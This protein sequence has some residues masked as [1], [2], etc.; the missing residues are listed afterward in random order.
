MNINEENKEQTIEMN[1]EE[2]NEV[3][4][5]T[6]EKSEN[7]ETADISSNETSEVETPKTEDFENKYKD[8]NDKYIRLYS[9]FD[10]FRRRTA[11][12]KLDLMATANASTI[13]SILPVVDDMERALQAIAANEN[14]ATL[15]EGI[16][17]IYNKLKNTLTQQGLTEM[18]VLHQVFNADIHEALTQIPAPS[19]DLKGKI[20]DVIEKGYYLND[21]VIRFAKVVVGN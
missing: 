15:K 12:E 16:E 21:K 11:K 17:L 20:V 6:E 18:E 8:A 19:D 4:N 3:K 9:E 14:A 1:N 5:N 13:K 10:N 7:D 2:L